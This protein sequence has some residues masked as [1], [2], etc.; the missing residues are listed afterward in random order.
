MRGVINADGRG[1]RFHAQPGRLAA[2]C[3]GITMLGAGG[4]CSGNALSTAA[5]RSFFDDQFALISTDAINVLC[6]P[7]L[8][9]L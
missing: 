6:R 9:L 7:G 8:L 5:K 2:G 3:C 1:V 4:R